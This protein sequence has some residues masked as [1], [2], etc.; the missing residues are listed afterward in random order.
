MTELDLE[1]DSIMCMVLLFSFDVRDISN[2]YVFM[3]FD[4][5]ENNDFSVHV[6]PT[7]KIT[8]SYSRG[9]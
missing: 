1:I 5:N 7:I 9:F 2:K 8:S 6:S 4:D 3:Y